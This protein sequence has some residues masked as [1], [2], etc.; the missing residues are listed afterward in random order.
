MS[1][2]EASNKK[3]V[4]KIFL[5]Q[6]NNKNDIFKNFKMSKMAQNPL[7]PKIQKFKKSY[8]QVSNIN[9]SKY[10]IVRIEKC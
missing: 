7:K 5:E 1:H 10:A 9:I 6:K 2:N 3:S 8:K 4:N